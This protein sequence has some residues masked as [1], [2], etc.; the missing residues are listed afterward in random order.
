MKY[1][2]VMEILELAEYACQEQEVGVRDLGLLSSAAHRPESQMFG[3]EAYP[4]LFEK[5]AALLHS[6]AINHPFVDGNKRTAW[7]SAVVFLDLNGA[8]MTGID[9]D[10]AYLLV[11]GV[12]AGEIG[13]VEAIAEQLRALHQGQS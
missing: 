9:Q 6:L 13:D 11:V 10:A 5:A 8:E 2:S 1:L 7:M 4:G 12:A 3:V